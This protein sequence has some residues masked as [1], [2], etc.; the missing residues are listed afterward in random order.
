MPGGKLMGKLD[1]STALVN[2][3]TY[4]KKT[5]F[6]HFIV[7]CVKYKVALLIIT[8]VLIWTII[9]NYIPMYGA[10]I[11]FKDYRFLDGILASPWADM[12][13]FKYFYRFLSSY[14]FLRV[15][16][17]TV[18]ISGMRLLFAFP[19][20][21]LMAM[22]I[23]EIRSTSYKRIVQS[24]TY[25]PHFMSWVVLS[26]MIITILNPVDGVVNEFI[27]ILGFQKIPFL[28]KPEF[29]RP[30]LILS[31]IWKEAGW[32]SIVYLAAITSIDTEMYE[33]ADIDGATRLQKAMRIT[34]PSII[35][36]ILILFILRI[37][38]FLNAGFEDILNLYN[39]AVM[40]V[41]DV[42]DTY[43]YRVGLNDLQYSYSAAIGLFKNFVGAM[44]LILTNI[45]SK[46]STGQGIW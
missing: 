10:I 9:F 30:I 20:P 34:L 21:I 19:V 23:N 16:G 33:A 24:I 14:Q 40:D 42:I 32:G 8:P 46:R 1:S 35:P 43:V 13:G 11:A 17:N 38:S 4:R 22:L 39:P 12:H 7:E 37:G 25:L 27:S 26:V 41:G 44:L 28:L 6:Q 45:V 31:G 36:I 18:I 3:G 5:K 2:N 15:L 29:F